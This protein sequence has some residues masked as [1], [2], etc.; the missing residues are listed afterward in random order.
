[1][2]PGHE[3]CSVA[4]MRKLCCL[5]ALFL[6]PL[7]LAGCHG[8]ADKAG[9]NADIAAAKAINKDIAQEF[10]DYGIK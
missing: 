2:P 4:F 3:G 7:V 9:G 1:M 10:E 5:T 8:G 6:A